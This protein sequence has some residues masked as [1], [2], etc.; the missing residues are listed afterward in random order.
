[1]KENLLFVTAVYIAAVSVISVV[2]VIYDKYAAKRSKR[3]I[4]EKALMLLGFF[5]AAAVEYIAMVAVRHKTLHKKFMIGLPLFVIFHA[6]I[7]SLIYF[8]IF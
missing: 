4:S 3:R 8:K 5:G 2:C 6:V 1:M 7:L